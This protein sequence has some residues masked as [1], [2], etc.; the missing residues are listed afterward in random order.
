M[1]EPSYQN[2]LKA[3]KN[4]EGVVVET[5]TFY[6]PSLS[7]IYGTSIY[8]KLEN[9]QETGSFK[10]RGAYIKLKSLTSEQLDR[11]V[12]AV[13]AGNHGQAVA[14]HAHK[15]GTP[16]TIVMPSHTPPTKVGNTERWGAKVVLAGDTLN[17]SLEVA[18][19]LMAESALTFIHPYDDPEVI[20]GQ[21]TIGIEML[22][23][24]PDL[25]T[26]IIPVGGGGL[27]SGIAIAAKQLN[28]KIKIFGVEVE[29]YA[30][31]A[32]EIYGRKDIHRDGITLAE[33]IAVKSPGKLPLSILK[34]YLEDILVVREEDVELAV[35]AFMRYQHLIVEGAGAVGLSAL[36]SFPKLF[37]KQKVATVVCGGNIDPRMISSILIRG[38]VRHGRL[39][40]LQLKVE[41]IPGTLENVAAIIAHH[42]GNVLEVKHQRLLHEI[43]IKMAELDIVVETRG[44][45]HIN[46]ITHSLQKAGFAVQQLEHKLEKSRGF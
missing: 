42:Q 39:V 28:P 20:A 30:S 40:Y 12:I 4:L 15:L 16:A 7:D 33:G 37:K 34:K 25:D 22:E 23:A 11:G 10:E 46:L 41:D 17:Q 1:S 6:S 35:E 8:L 29:G 26:L 5:P 36:M 45:E 19:T 13:S 38:Q 18:Q 31:M 44:F 24:V 2:I 27:C 9:L 3:K 43:P 32:Q 14:F 21:G